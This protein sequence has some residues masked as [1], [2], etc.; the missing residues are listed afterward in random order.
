[1]PPM[2]T[3]VLQHEMDQMELGIPVLRAKAERMPSVQRTGPVI[4][5]GFHSPSA[6][7]QQQQQPGNTSYMAK[8]PNQV[9]I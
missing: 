9:R 1:M 4:G 5:S 2:F 6:V 8:T 7:Q 3:Q